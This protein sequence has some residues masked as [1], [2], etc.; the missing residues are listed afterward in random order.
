MREGYDC[1]SSKRGGNVA[2]RLIPREDPFHHYTTAMEALKFH[3]PEWVRAYRDP[4]VG[5]V[6]NVHSSADLELHRPAAA[7]VSP[8]DVL[9]RC[10]SSKTTSPF[11][12]LLDS[13]MKIP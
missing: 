13:A 10:I 5:V 8:P 6:E 11:S 2:H 3:F 12:T 1:H 4:H 9:C 7:P